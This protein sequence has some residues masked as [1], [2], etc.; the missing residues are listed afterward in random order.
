VARPGKPPRATRPVAPEP[1]DADVLQRDPIGATEQV[2]EEAVAHLAPHRDVELV[3]DELPVAP[4]D[5]EPRRP[6][7]GEVVAGVALHEAEEGAQLAH[8]GRALREREHEVQARLVAQHAQQA[9]RGADV[10]GGEGAAC[11]RGGGAV[12][13]GAGEDIRGGA[14]RRRRQRAPAAGTA[15]SGRGARRMVASTVATRARST[16]GRLRW[17]CLPGSQISSL[18]ARA[19]S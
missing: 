9:R 17:M 11:G 8:R 12:G 13:H 7:D 4:V 1:L 10:G 16:S 5:D 14:W 3:D 2:V 19:E 15:A 6:E 18:G